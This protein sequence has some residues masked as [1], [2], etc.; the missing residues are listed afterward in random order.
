MRAI[1]WAVLAASLIF[2]VVYGLWK[3]RKQ[4]RNLDGFILA[5]RNLPWWTI[6]LS[7]MA[8]QASAITFLSTP[9]QAYADGMR[10]IQFYL[11]LPIAMVILS[12]TAVPIY[13]RLK[14]YTAYEYLE[15]R[16]DL[17]TRSLAAMLFL[18]QRGLA[19]GLTI[20]APAVILS[21]ILGWNLH[22][23]NLI[24]GALVISYTASGGTRAV[25]YT[26]F[27][28]MLI[29]MGGMVAAF[30][31]IIRMLPSDISFGEAAYVAG[32]MGRL[33]AIDFSFDITN[34]YNFWSG[35]IG[36]LFVALAYF[37][38]DQSQ[39][40]RY[41]GGKSIAQSRIGLLFNGL[42]KV[43]MQFFIL[44][45]GAMVFVVYQFVAPPLF[46][47]TVETRKIAA[48][49]LAGDYVALE[50][51]YLAAWS[52]KRESVRGLVDAKRAGD[53]QAIE[54]ADQ[55]VEESQQRVSALRNEATTLMRANDPKADTNDTNY[56]FLT[57]VLTYLPAGLVGLV[58]AAVVAASMSSTS[59]ELNALAS[60]TVVDIYKRMVRKDAT[61]R[62]YVVVSKLATVFWGGFAILF[63]EYANR[64]GSLIEAVNILGSLFYGTILGIFLLAFYFRNVDGSSTFVAALIAEAIV[65]WCWLRTPISWLWYNVVGCLAVIAIGVAISAFNGRGGV[66]RD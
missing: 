49:P 31:V 24:I 60:T 4:G 46:F 18:T 48:S 22:L 64:L 39:V 33:N 44:F 14:V 63:A 40:G 19:C 47:N 15:G 11:G 58:L 37:G 59:S 34:R 36:G 3:G 28:Q 27:Q 30:V 57:F 1:D 21:V 7:I 42:F 23:T 56:V 61:E 25:N 6:A 41:L 32:K 10:F 12:V 13:H 66:V 54:S 53:A 17:K 9:G 52:D 65:V 29:I 51:E 26:N 16:F 62:H 5:D 55:R 43:P 8:T 50:G 20:Y 38:T 45:I 2:I 35:L